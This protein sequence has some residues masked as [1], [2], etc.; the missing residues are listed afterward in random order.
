VIVPVLM[1]ARSRFEVTEDPGQANPNEPEG[2]GG[3]RAR[4]GQATRRA[5]SSR[6]GPGTQQANFR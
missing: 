4:L 3:T 5:A 6:R 1:K 2:R